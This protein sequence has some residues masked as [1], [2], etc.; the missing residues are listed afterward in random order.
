[1]T[2]LWGDA[3]FFTHVIFPLRFTE[4]ER[5][6]Q[7][8]KARKEDERR[9]DDRKKSEVKN[10][11]PNQ[12]DSSSLDEDAAVTKPE[13]ATTTVTPKPRQAMAGKINP[14]LIKEEIMKKKEKKM[15]EDLPPYVDAQAVQHVQER[16]KVAHAQSHQIVHN[17]AVSFEEILQRFERSKL[18]KSLIWL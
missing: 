12:L 17:E 1:M 9:R 8:E 7:A 15:K 10:K 4:K 6:R 2:D 18:M 16:P 14:K 3:P 13:A 11:K 5:Q